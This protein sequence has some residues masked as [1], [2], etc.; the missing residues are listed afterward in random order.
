VYVREF[1]GVGPITVSEAR[2]VGRDK[3][4]AIGEPSKERLE[5]PRRRWKSVQEKNRRR[6]F[7]SGL[8]VKDGQAIY[9]YRAIKS[10][11]LHVIILSLVL[12]QQLK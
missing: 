3:V 6:V 5:H 4:I 11:V 8:S 12:G 7:R 10:R 9:L 1:L 2:V